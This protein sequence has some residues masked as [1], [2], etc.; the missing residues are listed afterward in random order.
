MTVNISMSSEITQTGYEV[1]HFLLELFVF[2]NVCKILHIYAF[3]S[4]NKMFSLVE[5]VLWLLP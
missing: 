3:Y 5:T 4:R 1:I 2:Q